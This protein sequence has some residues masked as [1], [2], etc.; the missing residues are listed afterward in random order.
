[1]EL[2]DNILIV[3]CGTTDAIFCP[4]RDWQIPLPGVYYERRTLHKKCGTAWRGSMFT[5]DAKVAQRGLEQVT[6]AG[7]VTVHHGRSK[8]T[9][10][11]L[12]A[13]G[14]ERARRMCGVPTISDSWP[15]LAA[16]SQKWTP[17]TVF[18]DGMGWGDGQSKLLVAVQQRMAPLLCTGLVESNATTV[19]HVYYRLAGSIPQ[20]PAEGS[21]ETSTIERAWDEYLNAWCDEKAK[22]RAVQ[23]VNPGEIG[24]IPLSACIE[25][26]QMKT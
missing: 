6:A 13:A 5:D 2:G 9:H 15:M 18:S 24:L 10:V 20:K 14:D 16:L 11:R 22:L 19:G 3:L 17:E 25:N 1:M 8:T 26:M 4:L 7:Y 21:I 23:P 12:T